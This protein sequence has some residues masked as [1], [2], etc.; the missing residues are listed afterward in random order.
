[1]ARHYNR[2]PRAFRRFRQSTVFDWEA[3][4]VNERPSEFVASTAFALRS[5]CSTQDCYGMRRSS[6]RSGFSAVLV[7]LI[8]FLVLCVGGLFGLARL[9]NG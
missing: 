2:Y 9:V 3:E 1:M 6:R 8:L 7:A 4:P 5:G